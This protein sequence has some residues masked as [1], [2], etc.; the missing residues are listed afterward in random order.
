MTQ[1]PAT[2]SVPAVEP[3]TVGEDAAQHAASARR[4]EAPSPPLELQTR[5]MVTVIGIVSLILVIVAVAT[6]AVLGPRAGAE[7]RQPPRGCRASGRACTAAAAVRRRVTRGVRRADRGPP[8]ARLPASSSRRST[9]PS[10]APYIDGEGEVVRLTR[11]RSTGR[12]RASARGASPRSSLGRRHRRLPHRARAGRH[13]RRSSGSRVSEVR[14]TIGADAHHDR[15]GHRRRPAPARR[16]D[17]LR[18]SARASSPCVPS[19]TPPTRVAA[20]PLDQG[21]VSI[22]ERVPDDEADPRTE[23]GRVG[24][25]AEHPARPRRRVAGRAPAQRGADAAIR[26]RREPRAAH[27]ARLDPRLLRALAA[28][29]RARAQGPETVETTEASLERIQAQSLRMT[30]LV[31][32]LLL[33]ARLDEGRSSSTAPSTCRGSRSRRSA[34]RRPAGPDH[35][36]VLDVGEEPVVIAGDTGPP[37]PGRRQPAGQRPHPHARGNER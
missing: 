19:P 4:R 9:A 30:T 24:R 12:R 15:A 7:P 2:G 35:S 29:A 33:L 28:R 22:T 18:R 26:R 6:S 3:A 1:A 34:T 25:R 8:G 14:S 27:A 36:W 23:I 37:A 5:L 11:P 10:P 21:E 17:R 32:D 16:R 13:L 20:L 31:E